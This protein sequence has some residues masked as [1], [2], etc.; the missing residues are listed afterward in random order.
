[1][2]FFLLIAVTV[3]FSMNVCG[4]EEHGV[5]QTIADK[6]I[7]ESVQTH[8]QNFQK[9]IKKYNEIRDTHL[10]VY[11]GAIGKPIPDLPLNMDDYYIIFDMLRDI[12]SKNLDFY[13]ETP[14]GSGEAAEEIVRFIRRMAKCKREYR[15][16][17]FCCWWN[18]S[19]EYK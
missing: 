2:R 17:R 12:H 8:K 15:S 13:I 14:G 16:S 6:I 4:V 5:E 3:I 9:L 18:K 10:I 1:M 19:N 7:Y 11:A